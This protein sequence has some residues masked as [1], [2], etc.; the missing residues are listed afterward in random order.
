MN[1]FADKD[2]LQGSQ[3]ALDEH[4]A[5]M[6]GEEGGSL[7]FI[8]AQRW[9]FHHKKCSSQNELAFKVNFSGFCSPTSGTDLVLDP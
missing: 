4:R 9:I 2:A 1:R 5:R 3:A 6:R 7:A 8:C